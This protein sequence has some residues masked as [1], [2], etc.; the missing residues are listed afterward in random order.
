M[1][2]LPK[3]FQFKCDEHSREHCEKL[4]IDTNG[5][6]MEIYFNYLV[7]GNQIIDF[8]TDY[9]RINACIISLADYIEEPPN[10]FNYNN[11]ALKPDHSDL[12][13]ELTGKYV[14]AL[15]SKPTKPKFIKCIDYGE[16]DH[17]TDGKIY[18]IIEESTNI[19]KILN[20]SGFVSSYYK[21][22]FE[23]VNQEE[24]KNMSQ[25]LKVPVTDVLRIHKIACSTWKPIIVDYLSRVDTDQMVKFDEFEIKSMFN[26]S[27]DTQKPV[28]EEIFGKQ[29]KPIE[30]GRIKTGSVVKIKWT[31]KHC[32]SSNGFDFDQ[33]VD[34]VFYK[35]KHYI[36]SE[37]RFS[38]IDRI[39]CTFH[40]DGKY[41]VFAADQ[42]VD[43]ITEVIEY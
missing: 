9:D 4:G 30:W 15:L 28:L 27:N 35:T 16:L 29:I 11:I 34:V 1:K 25:K 41:S 38:Y 20:D 23:I 33:P 22:R 18:E 17:I 42:N 32:S 10:N 19:Y 14:Q 7:I 13:V 24:N 40:Q 2:P 6:D 3:E 21:H 31:G 39:N 5:F 26:A 8:E 12:I 43:Y 37:R 36:S